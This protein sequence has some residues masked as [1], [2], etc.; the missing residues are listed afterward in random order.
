MLRLHDYECTE[1]GRV[2]EILV[3]TEG[4]DTPL[5]CG[6]EMERLISAPAIHTL[7][8]HMRGYRTGPGDEKFVPSYGEFRDENLC[9]ENGR[10]M[11]YTSPREKQRL[12]KERGLY[13]KGPV[14]EADKRRS[15]RRMIFTREGNKRS[16]LA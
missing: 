15:E 9:D 6:H 11:T 4:D 2:L 7:E 16:Q 12:L 8:S 10:P 1:C 3:D 5:H 14:K 13:E